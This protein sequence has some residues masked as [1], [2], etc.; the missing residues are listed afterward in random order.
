MKRARS[1][2]F[3][4]LGRFPLM[5]RPLWRHLEAAIAWQIDIGRLTAGARVP[6]TRALARQLRVSRNTVALAY[7][8]LAADGYLAARVGDG[9]YVLDHS[10]RTRPAIWRRARTWIHDP[11]GLLMWITTPNER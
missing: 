3:P 6:S 11:D 10:L 7:D 8:A 5:R 9:S 1:I 4:R 2:D